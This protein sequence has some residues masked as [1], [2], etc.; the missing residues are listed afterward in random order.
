MISKTMPN[1]TAF[2]FNNLPKNVEWILPNLGKAKQV[3]EY[4][5]MGVWEWASEM[6]VNRQPSTLI[7]FPSAVAKYRM[8]Q[9]FPPASRAL[10]NTQAD[11]GFWRAFLPYGSRRGRCVCP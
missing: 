5:S 10:V 3:W 4:E 9:R 8:K 11:R 6:S 1:S 7:L 2:F